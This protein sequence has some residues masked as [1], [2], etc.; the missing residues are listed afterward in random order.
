[1]T[2]GVRIRIAAGILL[3][4]LSPA[5]GVASGKELPVIGGKKTIALVNGEPVTLKEFRQTLGYMHGKMEEKKTVEKIDYSEPLRRLINGKLILYEARNIGIDELPEIKEMME[6][7]SK[8]TLIKFLS[9]RHI[10]KLRPDESKVNKLYKEKTREFK[11]KSAY[12]SKEEDA[13]EVKKQIR[14]GAGFDNVIN[15]L[16]KEGKAEGGEKGEYVKSGQLLPHVLSVLSGMKPGTISPVIS[17]G[18]GFTLLKLEG[19]RF[20]EDPAAKEEARKEALSLKRKESLDAY[21]ARLKKRYV[22]VDKKLLDAVDYE[23]KDPGFANLLKDRRIIARVKGDDPVSIADLTEAIQKEYFHGVEK[24]IK[25]KKINGMKHVVFEKLVRERALLHEAKSLRIDKS[26]RYR[27]A[28]EQHQTNLVF[29]A[30][31]RKVIDPEIKIDEAELRTY[32]QEHLEEHTLP[33][34]MRIRNLVFG[35]RAAAEDALDKL[36]AG[37]DLKW[38]KENADHQ[39]DEK[40]GENLLSFS[41]DLIT[42]RGLPENVRSSVEGARS[43][44]YRLVEDSEGRFH[45]L[46][47][48]E[49]VPPRPETFENAR[50]SL[51]KKMVKEKRERSLEDW[52]ERLRAA[53]DIKI[54]AT[55]TEL[56]RAIKK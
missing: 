1:M 40:S 41:G 33:E 29:N 35:E 6:K 43:G 46:Y 30:F 20:P 11:I 15:E 14:E 25:E 51:G 22:K 10:R 27:D 19:T 28:M 9:I 17:V 50:D 18:K 53:S 34:M 36:R 38:V 13:V 42:T 4:V 56:E 26:Q 54:L 48:Q 2:S 47:I 21:A 37:A 3:L 39:V 24:A 23:A 5:F 49:V 7:Y 45:V 55:D 52:A 44:D 32:F 8:E 12:F 16:A 31:V